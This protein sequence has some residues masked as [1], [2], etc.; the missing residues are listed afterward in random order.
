MLIPKNILVPLD[1]SESSDRLLEQA[2]AIASQF[3]ARVY[4]LHVVETKLIQC[5]DDYCLN[6]ELVKQL[7]A[8]RASQISDDYSVTPLLV[9]RMEEEMFQSSRARLQEL[10]NRNPQSQNLETVI[11]VR[12]GVAYSEIIAEQREQSIDL[13]IMSSL[14][15]GGLQEY[16]G[17]TA[18]KVVRGATCSVMVIK[19]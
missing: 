3:K 12:S 9:R 5:I 18:E 6:Q 19:G 7:A 14:G 16:L 15:K 10:I 13:I 17:S 2:F 4:V 11:K 8:N 1:F